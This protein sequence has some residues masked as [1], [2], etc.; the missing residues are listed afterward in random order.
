MSLPDCIQGARASGLQITWN[1]RDGTTIDLTSRTI[2]GIIKNSTTGYTQ[3]ITGTL[4]VTGTNVFTWAFS[5]ADVAT[6]GRYL[7]RFRATDSGSLYDD[8]FEEDWEV[9]PALS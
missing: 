1:R 4:T 2:T 5:A 3:A 9:R 7:V 8:T 6:A